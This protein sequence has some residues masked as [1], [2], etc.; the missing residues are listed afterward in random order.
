MAGQPVG[1]NESRRYFRRRGNATSGHCVTDSAA[2]N[3]AISPV[4]ADFDKN[5]AT[6]ADVSRRMLTLEGNQLTSI[7]NGGTALSEGTD[8][9]V[10]GNVGNDQQIV[11]GGA[12][13]RYDAAPV[14]FQCRGISD[15]L[16]RYSRHDA[17]E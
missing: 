11:L 14:Y 2:N 6:Q 1:T 13:D 10:S 16:N 8:Y 15:S 3:S 7:V 5:T 17:A 4:S 9:T 12:A